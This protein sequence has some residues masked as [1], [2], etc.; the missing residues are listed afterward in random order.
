MNLCR[1]ISFKFNE[2][3]V[4]YLINKLNSNCL[5]L[6][7]WREQKGRKQIK[8]KKNFIVKKEFIDIKIKT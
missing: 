5:F 4:H 1:V 3:N 6:K 2:Q 7:L 8:P